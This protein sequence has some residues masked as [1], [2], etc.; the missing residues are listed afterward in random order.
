MERVSSIEL[1]TK[2]EEIEMEYYFQQA[3]RSMNPVVKAL[4]KNLAV[5]EHLHKKQIETLHHKLTKDGSWPEDVPIEVDGTNIH[6]VLDNLLSEKSPAAQVDYDD[7]DVAALQKAVEFEAE[8]AKFY[9]ELAD[10]CTNPQEEK[11]FRT[12]SGIEREH[13]LSIKD[14]LFYLEDPQGW[15]E[16]KE[17][18]NL[19][20]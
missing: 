8:A 3:K 7:D 2:N 14:S 6:A 18:Q 13:M 16:E 11:F 19:E 1:A 20:G 15:L 5:E 4:F 12:L 17:G 9:A 10:A